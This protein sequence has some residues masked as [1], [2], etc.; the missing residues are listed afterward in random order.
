MMTVDGDES[1]DNKN[2]YEAFQKKRMSMRMNM[3]IMRRV[4]K[5]IDDDDNKKCSKKHARICKSHIR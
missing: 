1:D 4:M 3:I 5:I 2:D